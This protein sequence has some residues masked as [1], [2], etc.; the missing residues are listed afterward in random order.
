M[1]S[2]EN[3]FSVEPH[4][5]TEQSMS[6]SEPCLVSSVF[7]KLR[8]HNLTS[9]PRV[10]KRNKHFCRVRSTFVPKVPTSTQAD[11]IPIP[12]PQSSEF[13]SDTVRVDPDT[14]LSEEI[15][16]K[17]KDML[18][19]YDSVFNPCFSGYHGVSGPLDAKVNLGPIQPPQRKGTVP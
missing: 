3:T 18:R 15:R 8:I 19:K 16:M 11:S 4:I 17:F 2:S 12:T 5:V 13:Y 14:V 7:G 1:L 6:W 10:L 9:A